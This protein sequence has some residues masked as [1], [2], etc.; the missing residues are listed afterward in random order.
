MTLPLLRIDFDNFLF[1]EVI[2]RPNITIFEG[3]G[4]KKLKTSNTGVSAATQEH[5][6]TA[7][8]IIA[9]DGA[10][11][12]LAKLSGLSEMDP[13]HHRAGLRVY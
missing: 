8:L 12:T 1:L 2:K 7:E 4:L 6:S 9:A 5:H 10:Y 13:K 3:S 11:S